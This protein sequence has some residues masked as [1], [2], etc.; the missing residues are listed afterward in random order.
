MKALSILVVL[1]M[2]VPSSAEEKTVTKAKSGRFEVTQER[3]EEVIETVR[4]S[5]PKLAP[6]Q[7]MGLAWPGIYSISPDEGW[8]LRTQKTGSGESIALLYRVEENG[9]VSEILGFDALLWVTSDV[10]SPLKRK[11]LFHTGI[12][13]VGWLSGVPVLEIVLSG[14][15]VSKPGESVKCRMAYDLENHRASL[16]KSP[17]QNNTNSRSSGA[18]TDGD[19]PKK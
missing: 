14:A 3:R 12:Q 7:L 16:K 8:L 4:F 9:R 19:V 5:D 13:D 15:S 6:V 10:T 17:S 1:I 2:A 18:G 11:D